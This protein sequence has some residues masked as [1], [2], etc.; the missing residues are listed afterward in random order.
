[1]GPAVDHE[2]TGLDESLAADVALVRPLPGVDAD[3]AVELAGVLE[4]LAA[5]IALVGTLV[6]VDPAVDAEVLL[7]A[8]GLVTVLAL[9][10]LLPGVD[11]VVAGEAGRDGEGLVALVAL[12]LLLQES[13]EALSASDSGCGCGCGV[14]GRGAGGGA[15][16]RVGGARRD[17]A[18]AVGGG[19]RAHHIPGLRHSAHVKLDVVA[20]LRGA[21]EVEAAELALDAPLAGLGA[22]RSGLLRGEEGAIRAAGGH[23][24]R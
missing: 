24:F 21:V 18:G 2:L 13:G 12:V 15:G 14:G 23:E 8:E 7:D 16:A 22:W 20:V 10:G 3:V 1:M 9:E 11:A 19:G 5:G 17:G 6:G 4:A